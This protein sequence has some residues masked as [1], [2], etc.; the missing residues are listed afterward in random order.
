MSKHILILF[1]DLDNKYEFLGLSFKKMMKLSIFD[2][3]IIHI[4][5]SN[6]MQRKRIRVFNGV[7]PGKIDAGFRFIGQDST[8]ATL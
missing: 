5:K 7:S 6:D 1:M 3:Q 4:K 8:M 2:K